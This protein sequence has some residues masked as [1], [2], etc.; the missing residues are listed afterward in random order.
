MEGTTWDTCW[1]GVGGRPAFAGN[2]TTLSATRQAT[3]P[4]GRQRSRQRHHT[5]GNA[6][7]NATDNAAKIK[8]EIQNGGAR[9]KAAPP[10]F[11]A[12]FFIFAALSVALPVALPVVWWRCLLRCRERGGVACRVAE[13]VVALPAKASR[14]P[15]PPEQVSQVVPSLFPKIRFFESRNHIFAKKTQK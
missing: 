6:T 4:R 1:G 12:P 9:P 15:T 3:P 8:K 13:S 14:P 7:G 11:V 2:A 10:H 5:T